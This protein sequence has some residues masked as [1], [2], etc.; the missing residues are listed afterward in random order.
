MKCE[1]CGEDINM[2]SYFVKIKEK[3]YEVCHL[4]YIMLWSKGG[5]K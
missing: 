3:T 5:E 4:C 2:S 1:L